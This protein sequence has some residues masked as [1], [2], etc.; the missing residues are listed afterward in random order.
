MDAAGG[1]GPIAAVIEVVLTVWGFGV[2]H[3]VRLMV[4]D[5]IGWCRREGQASAEAHCEHAVPN[6]NG[7]ES[8]LK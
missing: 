6:L 4:W 7:H 1:T 5:Q 3:K 2:I 8:A